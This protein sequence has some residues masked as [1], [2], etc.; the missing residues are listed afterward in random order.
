MSLVI[1]NNL[2]IN[3]LQLGEQLSDSIHSGRRSDFSLLLAMLSDDVREHSQ[4]YLP[5]TEKI[6]KNV[7]DSSLRKEFHLPDNA[8]LALLSIEE[9][10]SFNQ[11]SLIE[12][13]QLTTLKLNNVLNP[14][15]LAF[16]NNIKHIPQDVMSNTSLL[17]QKKHTHNQI[18]QN[19][20]ISNRL[21]FNAKGWLDALQTSLVKSPLV[22]V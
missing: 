18:N 19:A 5:E 12:N 14:K 6:R 9:V 10:G 16:R 21:S 2:L 17:C 3:E 22:T 15:A 4:F 13:N 11:A 20:P 7:S 1:E 8:P